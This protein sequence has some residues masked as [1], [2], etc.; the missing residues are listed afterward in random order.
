MKWS[1]MMVS[2]AAFAIAGCEE[3]SPLEEAGDTVRDGIED[4]R[5]AAEDAAD[6][7]GDAAEEVGEAIDDAAD[8]LRD[9]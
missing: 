4:A 5:E 3:R 9:R 2:V 1:V 8:E 7:V 6:E